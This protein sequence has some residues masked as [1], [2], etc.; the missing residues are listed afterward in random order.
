LGDKTLFEL[1]NVLDAAYGAYA[2]SGTYNGLSVSDANYEQ[3]PSHERGI[4]V[5]REFLADKTTAARQNAEDAGAAVATIQIFTDAIETITEKLI[6]MLELAKQALVPD[7]SQSQV[8]QMQ[9]QFQNLAR[10]E[11]Q[12]ADNTEFK[13]NGPSSGDG[14]TLSIPVGDGSK[15]DIHAREFHI[16]A[17]E[18]N[19]E[20]DPQNALLKVNEAIKNINEYKTY[21]DQQDARLREITAAVELEIQG[22]MSVDMQDFQPELAAPMA[23]Y[24]ASLILQDKQTSI[25]VQA[26]LTSDEILK[27]LKGND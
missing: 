12:I 13:F 3:T 24:T 17:R 20:T 14:E 25:D 21:F 11:N 6:K 22:V 16:D 4:A 19:I 5:I 2:F 10:Q 9:K 15:I 7:Y 8:E 1:K 27:L 18:L 23:D 26:N